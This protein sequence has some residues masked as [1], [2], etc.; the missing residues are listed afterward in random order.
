LSRFLKVMVY[1]QSNYTHDLNVVQDLLAPFLPHQLGF[2]IDATW[3]P[4][5]PDYQ[6]G[7]SNREAPRSIPSHFWPSHLCLKKP[8]LKRFINLDITIEDP[9]QLFRYFQLVREKR[10]NAYEMRASESPL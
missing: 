1:R 6:K 10:C 7:H 9:D 2:W 8:F 5:L 4:L 3:S